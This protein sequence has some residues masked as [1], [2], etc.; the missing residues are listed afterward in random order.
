MV[1]YH[2]IRADEKSGSD[3]FRR[4]EERQQQEKAATGEGS[5]SYY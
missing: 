2:K 5:R 4:I 1:W 3:L